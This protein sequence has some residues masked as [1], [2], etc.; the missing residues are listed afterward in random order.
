MTICFNQYISG[1]GGEGGGEGGV[2]VKKYRDR[3]RLTH[4]RTA[5]T[6]DFLPP[7]NKRLNIPRAS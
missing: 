4:K 2:E 1:G 6:E 3:C 5:K 7:L